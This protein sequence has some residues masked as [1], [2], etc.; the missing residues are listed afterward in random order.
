LSRTM[1]STLCR[2]AERA[3]LAHKEPGRL[4]TN[5][6]SGTNSAMEPRTSRS[7]PPRA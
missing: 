2:V 4:I 1:Y 5:P 7:N 6:E 3:G